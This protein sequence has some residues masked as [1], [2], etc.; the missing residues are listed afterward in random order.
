MNIKYA[1]SQIIKHNIKKNV[2]PKWIADYVVSEIPEPD[3]AKVFEIIET[4][5]SCLHEGSI[6]RYGIKLSE[7]THWRNFWK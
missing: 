2:A 7:Y 1:V 6:A 5:L 4:E 3:R